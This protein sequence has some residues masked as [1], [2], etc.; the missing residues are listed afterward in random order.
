MSNIKL[1]AIKIAALFW[2]GTDFLNLIM[3]K[4]Y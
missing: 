2:R 3:F 1:M 4:H